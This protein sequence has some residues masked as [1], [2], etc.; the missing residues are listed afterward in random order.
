VGDF[1]RL[2]ALSLLQTA[3]GLALAIT[4]KVIFHDKAM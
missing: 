3:I 2:A 4:L 1:S